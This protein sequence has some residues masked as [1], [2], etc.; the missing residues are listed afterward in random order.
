YVAPQSGKPGL[1]MQ[2][3]ADAVRQFGP[4]AAMEVARCAA[5]LRREGIVAFGLG[6]DELSVPAAAF[7]EVYDFAASR[8]LRGVA[9]A[10]EIGGPD[11]VRDAVEYLGAERVGH[12]I[13]AA[14]DSSL[15][16]L[17]AER[18][19]HLEICPTSNLRTG[20]LDR[21]FGASATMAQH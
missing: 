13:S 3:I 9:H 16:T 8:D 7:R 12:G 10:G 20:A 21:H 17:L 6:G 11:S 2:W 18:G 14:L 1:R 5:D 19:I 15:M 4:A